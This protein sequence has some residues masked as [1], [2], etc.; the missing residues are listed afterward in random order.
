MIFTE[1][2]FFSFLG[3]T[4]FWL[5]GFFWLLPRVN[6]P[7]FSLILSRTFCLFFS[8]SLMSA[9]APALLKS[10]MVSSATSFASWRMALAFSLASRRILSLAWSIFSFFFCNCSCKVRIRSLYSAISCCSFSMVTRLCSR[11][12]MTSSK[13]S[14][15]LLIC[16]FAAWMISSDSPSLEEMAKALLLPGIPMSRR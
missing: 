1:S 16:S 11:S 10:R 8:S 4:V 12:A 6:F 13:L 14:S 2:P 5:A 3:S 7:F 9:E 15:S